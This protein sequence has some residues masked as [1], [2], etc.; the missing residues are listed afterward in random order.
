MRL[1]DRSNN[2][3]EQG[4]SGCLYIGLII[5]TFVYPQIFLPVILGIFF[6]LLVNSAREISNDIVIRY[7]GESQSSSSRRSS[8]NRSPSSTYTVSPPDVP[9]DINNILENL[10]KGEIK[11]PVTQ[12]PFS[13]GQKVY[14]C[15]SHK[16][17]YHQDSWQEMGCKCISCNH[18]RHTKVYTLPQS[19][20]KVDFNKKDDISHLIQFEDLE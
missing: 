3:Q 9:D 16:L 12:E 19:R 18:S 14:L 8:L 4:C 15:L 11:D 7:N 20:I 1:F 2:S 6:Y 10:T 13:P 17:A 5:L